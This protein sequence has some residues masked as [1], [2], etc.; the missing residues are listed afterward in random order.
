VSAEND[1]PAP[2]APGR[3]RRAFE[4]FANAA[5][6]VARRFRTVLAHTSAA[7]DLA[8]AVKL[9]WWTLPGDGGPQFE[10]RNTL[11]PVQVAEIRARCAAVAA[12]AFRVAEAHAARV[13]TAAP[14]PRPAPSPLDGDT[15]N[16]SPLDDADRDDEARS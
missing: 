12:H 4:A 9:L 13:D 11:S 8:D 7:D 16:R 3:R 10:G 1:A 5:F 14:R 2:E 6:K 15:S